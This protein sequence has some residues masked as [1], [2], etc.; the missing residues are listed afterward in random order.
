M[1]DKRDAG[2]E[3]DGLKKAQ[4]RG[5]EGVQLSA[6]T[7]APNATEA[8]PGVICRGCGKPAKG[9]TVWQGDLI[10][11]GMPIP[12]SA[13]AENPAPDGL[14]RVGD[15]VRFHHM[16]KPFE[17]SA[18]YPAEKMVELAGMSGMFANSLFRALPKEQGNFYRP[19]APRQ[20][21]P[22]NPSNAT[23]L[24]MVGFAATG[25]CM[26][27]GFDCQGKC[28]TRPAANEDIRLRRA[29]RSQVLSLARLLVSGGP[30]NN[31]NLPSNHDDI[32]DAAA[33]AR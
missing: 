10:C 29:Q 23:L 26:V 4:L 32:Q 13:A 9:H 24:E 2:G 25:R 27:C 19:A 28:S 14:W 21:D 12:Q 15:R 8:A 31:E 17:V 6:P 22:N 18:T 20:L 33:G 5:A 11:P 1:L 3:V 7:A 30:G 16:E